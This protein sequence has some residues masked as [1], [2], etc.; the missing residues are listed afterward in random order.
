MSDSRDPNQGP[1]VSAQDMLPPIEPPSAGF[2][3]KLFVIPLLIVGV[4]VLLVLTFNWL[5]QGEADKGRFIQKLRSTQPDTWQVAHD[6]ATELQKDQALREDAKFAA[7]LAA[8]AKERIAIPPPEGDNTT[9]QSEVDLRVYLMRALGQFSVPQPQE[10]LLEAGR[11]E[12]NE[13]ERDVRLAALEGLA[14]LIHNV[15]AARR[16][17]QD[18]TLL[19]FLVECG[20]PASPQPVRARAAFALG[21][22]GGDKA[23][24]QLRKMLDDGY[25]DARFNAATGLARY[26]DDR[27]DVLSVLTEMLDPEQTEGMQVERDE[28]NLREFKRASIHI[29]GLRAVEF[30]VQRKTKADLSAIVTAIQRLKQTSDLPPPVDLQAQAVLN[31][32]KALK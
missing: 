9:A 28:G 10:V 2:I 13:N 24:E 11:L 16:T 27:A 15:Q 6:L 3:V 19:P 26:G 23:R 7:Q 29:N 4:V 14:E 20:Q 5:S 18:D 8:V 25:P 22:Q 31:Q 32:I 21:V 12:R 1:P 30:L 17:M